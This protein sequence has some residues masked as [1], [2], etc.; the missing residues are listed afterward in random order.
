MLIA[1]PNKIIRLDKRHKE[2]LAE[3][4]FASAHQNSSKHLNLNEMKK[5]ITCRLNK[6]QEQFFGYKKDGELVG[7]ISLKP[8]FPGHK[9]CE[10]YWLAVKKNQ[11]GQG[12][13]GELTTFIEKY[14]KRKGF[15]KICLYTGQNMKR[16]RTFYEKLGYR[17][18]NEFKEYYGYPSGNTT[19]A[20]YAKKL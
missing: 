11:Q 5:E 9:H 13:G 8:F 6:G 20:L 15:R 19:A 7:Y 17:F 16:T 4:D 18:V 14:A 3:I 10:L 2:Q 12:I 1:M